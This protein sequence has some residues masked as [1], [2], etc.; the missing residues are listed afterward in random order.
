[1]TWA[2]AILFI[3]WISEMMQT[4]I[5]TFVLPKSLTECL[6]WTHFSTWLQRNQIALEGLPW[7]VGFPGA[8]YTWVT[9]IKPKSIKGLSVPCFIT[10]L[11]MMGYFFSF[12]S[13][14]IYTTDKWKDM[15]RKWIHRSRFSCDSWHADNKPVKLT[16]F[17]YRIIAMLNS[18]CPFFLWSSDLAQS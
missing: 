10:Q 9:F 11:I 16:F 3:T 18:G 5:S 1:M 14:F 17:F 8:F 4:L 12:F 7:W 6:I 13:D 2:I 15:N